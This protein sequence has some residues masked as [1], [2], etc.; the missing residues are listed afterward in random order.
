MAD[1]RVMVMHYMGNALRASYGLE[2]PTADHGG[3]MCYATYLRK[4]LKKILLG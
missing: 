4:M 2:D 1:N 3:P